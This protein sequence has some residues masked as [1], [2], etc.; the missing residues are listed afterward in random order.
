[1]DIDK[2]KSTEKTNTS[3]ISKWKESFVSRKKV[4][5]R[6]SDS[7]QT[8]NLLRTI[9]DNLERIRRD[10]DKKTTQTSFLNTTL[11]PDNESTFMTTGKSD[12]DTL[13]EELHLTQLDPLQQVPTEFFIPFSLNYVDSEN[14]TKE[15]K[16]LQKVGKGHFVGYG[17][18]SGNGS[19]GNLTNYN[20]SNKTFLSEEC[21]IQDIPMKVCGSDGYTYDNLSQFYC[22]Q[23]QNKGKNNLFKVCFLFLY[24]KVCSYKLY[25]MNNS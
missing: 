3:L 23:K 15:Y 20:I 6:R 8:E 24:L 16:E 11:L 18:A 2:S 25:I 13:K 22:A 12:N 10:L 1:M 5:E 4:T 14:K 21:Q 19:L 7:N 9:K 17:I